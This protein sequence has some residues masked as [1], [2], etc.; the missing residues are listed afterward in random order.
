MG[1]G[2]A[3]RRLSRGQPGCGGAAWGARGPR[4]GWGL[5]ACGRRG[6]VSEGLGAENWALNTSPPPTPV[7]WVLLRSRAAPFPCSHT[8]PARPRASSVGLVAGEVWGKGV[9]FR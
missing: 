7:S 1:G 6:L 2:A 9:G 5:A 4:G 3:P 8:S